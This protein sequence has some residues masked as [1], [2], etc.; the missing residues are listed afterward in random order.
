M[1][2]S[3]RVARKKL[4]E[5]T[6]SIASTWNCKTIWKTSSTTYRR[7]PRTSNT[8]VNALRIPIIWWTQMRVIMSVHLIE[9]SD[10]ALARP[11][12][13]TMV[14]LTSINYLALNRPR[15]SKPSAARHLWVNELA[16]WTDLIP[17]S[18]QVPLTQE[19]TH[20]IRSRSLMA[21]LF[22][23]SLLTKCDLNQQLRSV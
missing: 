12:L 1:S 10:S 7:K 5:K 3:S 9:K 14:H 22:Q 19:D 8:T 16:Q 13:S 15:F 6:W 11:I 2:S 20:K 18:L 23:N 17:R 21:C 4:K